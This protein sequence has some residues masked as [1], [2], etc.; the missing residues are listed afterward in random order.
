VYRP[1][2][3]HLIQRAAE[4]RGFALDFEAAEIDGEGI[5]IHDARIE[6]LGVRGVR[7]DV[8]SIQVSLDGLSPR[9]ADASSVALAIEG[10]AADRLLELSAWSSD[11]PDF[12]RFPGTGSGIRLTWSARP[13]DPPWLAFGGGAFASTGAGATLHTS[14][15]TLEGIPVGGLGAAWSADAAVI[16]IGIGKETIADAPL[17]VALHPSANP[18]TADIALSPLKLEDLG[19]PMGV[20][21]PAPGSTVEGSA[22]LT[23]GDRAGRDAIEG[24]VALTIKGWVPPHPRQLDGIVFGGSTAFAARLRVS[25]DRRTVAISDATVT[26]GAFKLKGK[27][28]IERDVDHARAALDLDGAIACADVARSAATSDWG[29]VLGQLLGDVARH[30]VE[31]SVAIKV[32]VEADTRDLRAAKVR[33]EVGVGCGL[34]LPKVW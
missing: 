10:S 8:E 6:L 9:R 21:L 19:A 15:A 27:G 1:L 17:R 23:L 29:E 11:H 24:S 14:A 4:R 20:G 28:A 5:L 31:G 12:Y 32:R 25:E 13:G 26:A 22:R 18:P 33:H 34:R 16:A 3:R 7:A 30:T 2:L